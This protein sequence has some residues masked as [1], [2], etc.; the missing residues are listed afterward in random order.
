MGRC[1]QHSR[2]F[3]TLEKWNRGPKSKGARRGCLGIGVEIP[4]KRDG[5]LRTG[6]RYGT[7]A[8]LASTPV[9]EATPDSP[10]F[11]P[12]GYAFVVEWDPS[13]RFP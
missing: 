3:V 4:S 10:S 9:H 2:R 7:E 8:V 1:A 12:R 11:R 13:P 5:S 6:M